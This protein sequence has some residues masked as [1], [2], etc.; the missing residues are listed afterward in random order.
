M[1]AKPATRGA[2]KIMD[3]GTLRNDRRIKDTNEVLAI[4]ALRRW[5]WERM[6]TRSGKIARHL[7]SPGRPD[8][9]QQTA[10]YDGALTRVIDFE[11]ALATLDT[12]DQMM[13]IRCDADGDTHG[14]VAEQ[15]SMSVRTLQT[16]LPQARRKLAEALDRRSLL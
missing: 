5:R 14:V 3:N 13:L 4:S 15:L 10:R 8:K 9:R 6:Q 2:Q 12:Q 7:R 11:R 1:A 16:K